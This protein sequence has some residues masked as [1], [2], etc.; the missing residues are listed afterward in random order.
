MSKRRFQV[1]II[2]D[3]PA[4]DGVVIGDDEILEIMS[5]G[6][7]AQVFLSKSNDRYRHWVFRFIRNPYTTVLAVGTLAR[8]SSLPREE[9]ARLAQA[10]RTSLPRRTRGNT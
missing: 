8:R 1:I 5:G 10:G 9:Q 2:D 3:R 7:W 6:Q 4:L